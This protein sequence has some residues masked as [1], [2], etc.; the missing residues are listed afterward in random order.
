M[1]TVPEDKEEGYTMTSL[2]SVRNC[3][4]FAKGDLKNVVYKVDQWT[5]SILPMRGIVCHAV[6]MNGRDVTLGMSLKGFGR[7]PR[8]TAVASDA[9]D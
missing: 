5:Y 2:P 6:P 4:D 9:I 1:K 7:F 3:S 8:D